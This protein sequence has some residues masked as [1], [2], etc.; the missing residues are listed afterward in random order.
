MSIITSPAEGMRDLLPKEVQT[1]NFMTAKI[2]EVYTRYGFS[3]IETPCAD[4]LELFTGGEGGE[5]EKMLFKILKR[6]EK[7]LQSQHEPADMALRYDLTVPLCRFYAAHR[8]KLPNPFKSIQIGNVWRAERPQKGRYRQFVQCDID[9]IGQSSILAEIELISATA[10]ALL[11]LGFEGFEI[12]IND[13]R[14]LESMANFAGFEPK[15]HAQV[16]IIMDKL[17]KIGLEGVLNELGNA[18]FG[19]ESCNKIEEIAQKARHIKS[20]QDLLEALPQLNISQQWLDDVNT[21]IGTT[22][23]KK[24]TVNLDIFLVRGMGYYTGTIFEIQAQGYNS[25]IAGGGRYDKMIGKFLP[26]QIPA[27]GFSIG[28]ER[29]AQ[30]L[31]ERNIDPQPINRK[32]ALIYPAHLTDFTA[33][34]TE[35]QHMRTTENIVSLEMERKNK[36][37]QFKQLAEMGFTHFCSFNEQTRKLS[38]LKSFS[39][40]K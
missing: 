29:V 25:S 19:T 40:P 38:Q 31:M 23:S 20:V 10:E 33:L 4:R 17:D 3:Q 12:K 35:A 15:D 21:I 28:F 36:A 5:N 34:M 13:R 6:G 16:F 22:Q 26:E 37:A 8:A 9:I 14:L 2:L 18:G 11:S 27:C 30:I 7:L 1:R 39:E 24:Y 32:I